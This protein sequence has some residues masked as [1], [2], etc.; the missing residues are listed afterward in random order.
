[1]ALFWSQDTLVRCI[2]DADVDA[3]TVLAQEE[4]ASLITDEER[5]DVLALRGLLACHVLEH[6]LQ[7]RHLVNYGVNR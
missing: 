3:T 1:M 6:S 4:A 2:S 7:L 5:C